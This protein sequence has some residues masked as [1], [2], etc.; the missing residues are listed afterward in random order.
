VKKTILLL[1]C[2]FAFLLAAGCGGGEQGATVTEITQ[3]QAAADEDD[4]KT[5]DIL[6]DWRREEVR[7]EGGEFAF[8][9]GDESFTSQWGYADFRYFT[10]ARQSK[11]T[12]LSNPVGAENFPRLRIVA[13]S[14]IRNAEELIGKTITADKFNLKL[15][16]KK[17]AGIKG[18]G[19]VVI[20]AISEGFVQGSFN[21]TMEDGSSMSGTFRAMLNLAEDIEE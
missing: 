14:D 8:T 6:S 21:A 13:S 10:V 17:G 2:G 5:G 12:L 1:L 18:A 11:L 16:K 3:P 9:Y 20:D 19:T 15:E 4:V 7:G